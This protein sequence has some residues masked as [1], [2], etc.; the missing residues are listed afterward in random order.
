MSGNNRAQSSGIKSYL[1]IPSDRIV[2]RYIGIVTQSL[3]K[4]CNDVTLHLIWLS[5][6]VICPAP[7]SRL[8]HPIRRAEGSAH[9][10]IE[11]LLF[12][13]KHSIDSALDTTFDVVHFKISIIYPLC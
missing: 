8:I 10:L 7:A 2:I 4:K 13:F 1:K 6:L 12:R 5:D 9:I 3:R 11:R